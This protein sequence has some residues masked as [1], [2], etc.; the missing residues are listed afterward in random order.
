MS[1]DERH[2][3]LLSIFHY[4]LGGLMA[5]FPCF[6]F[7]HIGLGIAMVTGA[8][9]GEQD[10]PPAFMGW[11]FILIPGFFMVLAWTVAALVI[12]AGRRLKRR[13]HR[14][15]CFVVAAIEC[16]VFMPLGTIL[17]VFTIV[18]L[19]RESVGRLFEAGEAA[20]R[21]EWVER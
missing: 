4:V 14:T 15:Y 7:I 21:G 8:F 19:T 20:Q 3:D 6:F 11:F 12:V 1:D 13:V 18:V 10:A 5:L 9:D 17:G 16:L 2:L